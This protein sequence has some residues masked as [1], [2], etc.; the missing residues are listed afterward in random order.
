[1]AELRSERIQ[2]L[3]KGNELVPIRKTTLNA[4][5]LCVFQVGLNLLFRS[6]IKGS[7]Y[8]TADNEFHR[9]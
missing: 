3:F 1:M 4:P 8:V 6:V 5:A 7:G 2:L 9:L